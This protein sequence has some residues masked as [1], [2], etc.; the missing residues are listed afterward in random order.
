MLTIV[1]NEMIT[2]MAESVCAKDTGCVYMFDQRNLDELK[3]LF[4][5]FKR[6]KDTFGLIIQQ[7]NPYIL[8]RGEKIVMDDSNL[9]DP[10]TFTQKLLD[11][12]AEI[13]KLVSYSFSN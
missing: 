9:K 13:D 8:K 7:M 10:H 6:A 11:F 2:N 4:D 5:V 1:V 3:L 12:K